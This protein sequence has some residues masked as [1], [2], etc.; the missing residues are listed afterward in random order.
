MT[1]GWAVRQTSQK[2]ISYVSTVR[3]ILFLMS[4]VVREPSDRLWQNLTCDFLMKS[5]LV[6]AFCG[7]RGKMYLF[8]LTELYLATWPFGRGASDTFLCL[9]QMEKVGTGHFI[10]KVNRVLCATF[11]V[12]EPFKSF[13]FDKWPMCWSVTYWYWTYVG[14]VDNYLRSC[15]WL[16]CKKGIKGWTSY[17]FWIIYQFSLDWRSNMGIIRHAAD[18]LKG[19][20]RRG[21]ALTLH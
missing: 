11:L 14:N 20:L 9:F 7:F 5:Q 4:A 16:K 3:L 10:L 6:E 17:F 2:A 21:C 19:L 13:Y 12:L 1:R 15:C 18:R 8:K